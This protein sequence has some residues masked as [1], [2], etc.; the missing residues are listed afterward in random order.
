MTDVKAYSFG[1][2]DQLEMLKRVK[3]TSET[4]LQ[5]EII[6]S[7]YIDHAPESTMVSGLEFTRKAAIPIKSLINEQ[8]ILHREAATKTYNYMYYYFSPNC[9]RF[10]HL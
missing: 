9:F 6:L 4:M 8:T 1:C 3:D 10:A 5:I 2:N 7:S